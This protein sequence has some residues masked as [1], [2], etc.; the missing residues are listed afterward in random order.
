MS[1]SKRCW[2]AYAA[3]A[4]EFLCPLELPA[5]ATVAEA[6]AA[7]RARE[8]ERPAGLAV[9]WDT[10][11]VGIFGERAARDT[12]FRDGDRIELYRP[13]AQ[14]PRARRRARVAA[15]QPRRR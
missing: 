7:A 15:A 13:L 10:A 1:P 11:P 3:P 6:L 4:G 12:V 8:G 9:P 5:G 2:V 14:D